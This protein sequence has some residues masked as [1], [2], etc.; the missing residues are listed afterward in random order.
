MGLTDMAEIFIER[1]DGRVPLELHE[2]CENEELLRFPN[3][4]TRSLR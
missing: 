1:G 4:D 3:L 2:L